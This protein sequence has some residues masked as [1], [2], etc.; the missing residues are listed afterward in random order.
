MSLAR[1]TAFLHHGDPRLAALHAHPRARERARS[2]LEDYAPNDQHQAETRARMLAFLER[3]TEALER[4]C[5]PGH[6]TASALVIDVRRER[7]L[8]GLHKKLGRWLQLGG[9]CE[10]DGNLA[11]SALREASE[12]SGIQ[13]LAIDPR[14]IDLDIH[15]IPAQGSEPEHLHL[16]VRFVVVA[17]AG[18]ESR[19]SDESL[20]LRWFLPPEVGLVPTDDSVRRLFRLALGPEVLSS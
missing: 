19:P 14:P 6:F 10:G 20:E 8:L 13:D 18:A 5:A 2:F 16:D 3:H 11:G 15:A 4:S 17:P 9:H 12:E 1:T 7:A